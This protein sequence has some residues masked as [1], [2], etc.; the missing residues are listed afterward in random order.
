MTDDAMMT[1]DKEMISTIMMHIQLLYIAA[2]M[3]FT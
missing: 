3:I 1:L 2:S